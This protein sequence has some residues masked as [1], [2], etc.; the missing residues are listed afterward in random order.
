MYPWVRSSQRAS[1]LPCPRG[2]CHSWPWS[3]RRLGAGPAPGAPPALPHRDGPGPGPGWVGRCPA[4]GRL[5]RRVAARA[6]GQRLTVYWS[7]AQQV[8]HHTV[9]GCNIRAG[10]LIT[11]GTI[12]GPAPESRGCLLSA[13]G[14]APSRYRCRTAPLGLP[15]G[16]HRDHPRLGAGPGGVAHRIRRVRGHHPAG[17]CGGGGG[18]WKHPTQPSTGGPVGLGGRPAA[19]ARPDGGPEVR[20][21]F[22]APRV[23]RCPAGQQAGQ[24]DSLRRPAGGYTQPGHGP[25]ASQW[26]YGPDRAG[27]P[28]RHSW[29][30]P[31]VVVR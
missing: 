14:A 20:P 12:S 31:R 5:A 9:S 21:T 19:S 3:T 13:R 8:A 27:G 22:S 4:R 10:D 18:A 6:D 17:A 16:L 29:P 26:G 15:R 11:T 24:Q 28:E 30:W 23:G 2:W 25:R 7:L 1:A